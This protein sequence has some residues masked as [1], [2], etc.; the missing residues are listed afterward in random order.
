MS[1]H[2]MKI[3]RSFAGAYG[4]KESELSPIRE[5]SRQSHPQARLCPSA[6]P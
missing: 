3:T 1:Y 5:Q 4:H 2:A 6:F